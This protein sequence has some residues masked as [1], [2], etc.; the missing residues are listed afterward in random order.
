[1]LKKIRGLTLIELIMAVVIM[2]LVIVG[3]YNIET[4]SNGQVIDSDRRAKVQN[5]LAYILEHMSKYVQQAN[6]NVINPTFM[7]TGTGFKARVDLNNPQTPSNLAD[8]AWVSYSL[9]GNTLSTSCSGS[10]GTF[11]SENL[12]DKII[13]NFRPNT[14]MPHAPV[15]GFYVEIDPAGNFVDV[16]LV[17]RYWPAE[18]PAIRK[19]NP[20]VE[21]RAKLICNNSSA[22]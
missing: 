7:Y 9:S 22:N 21:M 3:I 5:D 17:G 10:C 12:S 8:D 2:S 14:I 4:F 15:D 13:A 1:M 20:Q 11:V 19:I 16:G 6:G 18:S